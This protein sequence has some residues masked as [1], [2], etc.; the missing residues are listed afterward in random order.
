MC[1]RKTIQ[2]IDLYPGDTADVMFTMDINEYGHQRNLQLIVK[3][4]RLSEGQMEAEQRDRGWYARIQSGQ[5]L[6]GIAPASAILPDRDD[7]AAV[8]TVI[9][10]ELKVDRDA[11]T[12]RGLSYLV[13]T[14]G[15]PVGYTKLKVILLTFRELGLFGVTRLTEDRELFAFRSVNRAGKVDLMSAAILKKLNEDLED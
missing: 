12:I 13:A 1:F 3:D 7:F 4:A 10:R 5:T 2:E 11:F 8:Y 14:S 15:R 9:R 6:R